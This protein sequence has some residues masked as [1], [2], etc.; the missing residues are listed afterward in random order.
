MLNLFTFLFS[1]KGLILMISLIALVFI[2]SLWNRFIQSD[3]NWF[4]EQAY[5]LLHEGTV[6]LKSMP[7]VNN[8]DTIIYLYYKLFIYIG[9]GLIALFGF[10]IW[11]LKLFTF[12]T[13]IIFLFVFK[14]YLRLVKLDDNLTHWLLPVFFI[15]S[16][17]LFL[18]QVIIFRPDVPLMLMGFST[19]YF[20]QKYL[21]TDNI[22][23]AF[24]AGLLAGTSFLI[25]LNGNVFAITGFIYLLS[26]KKFKGL[27]RFS[28]AAFLT[29]I[30]YLHNLLSAEAIQGV[31]YEFQHIPNQSADFS[32]NIIVNRLLA[33]F[34]EQQRFFWSS[35]V[36]ATSVLMIVS[37]LF[38]FKT[39]NAKVPEM[40]RFFVI[41]ILILNLFGGYVAERFLIYHLPYMAIIIAIAITQIINY[42]RKYLVLLFILVLIFQTTAIA[43]SFNMVFNNNYNH[44]VLHNRVISHIPEGNRVLAPWN[45][46][47]NEIGNYQ[48]LSE[49]NI[50]YY[51]YK[52]VNSDELK[53]I[54]DSLRVNYIIF[55][56]LFEGCTEVDFDS[57]KVNGL[58]NYSPIYLETDYVVLQRQ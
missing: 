51:N 11:P 31:I 44:K 28:I 34:S 14:K 17:P 40:L 54:I 38:F 33:I 36:M 30:L 22:K 37:L 19:F 52:K 12:F 41:Q 58:F 45:F 27:I 1:R 43:S 23:Y 13:F 50:E 25:H 39:I 18:E 56:D 4:G 9:S 35:R 3:E 57:V 49:K 6:K 29:G 21:R 2:A 55:S 42:K 20:L 5:W 15:V 48:I 26:Y 46:I 8:N 16:T 7:L 47:Y 24:I 10:S 32:N 53:I